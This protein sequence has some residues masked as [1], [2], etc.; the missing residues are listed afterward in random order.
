MMAVKQENS[1]FERSVVPEGLLP[2]ARLEFVGSGFERWVDEARSD[3]SVGGVRDA[4]RLSLA[5]RLGWVF[6][7]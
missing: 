6:G 3:A 4:G 7:H 5:G 2:R 1:S